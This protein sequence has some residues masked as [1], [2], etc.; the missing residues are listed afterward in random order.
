M[1]QVRH[2]RYGYEDGTAV[3]TCGPDVFF[4]EQKPDADPMEV[5]REVVKTLLESQ[6]PKMQ[7]H[8]L[9][10]L[11][12]WGHAGCSEQAIADECGCT[13]A[14]VSAR[15]MKLKNRIGILRPIGPMRQEITQ[16]RCLISRMRA[17]MS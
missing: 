15:I 10:L 4:D 14:A 11:F 2:M 6:N 8:I 16:V 17:S 12:E 1:L 13:R 9:A 5:A 3:P 7:A